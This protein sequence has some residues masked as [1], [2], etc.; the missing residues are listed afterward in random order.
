M[1]SAEKTVPDFYRRGKNTVLSEVAACNNFKISKKMV[2][3]NVLFNKYYMI[4]FIVYIE[5]AGA[6]E[7]ITK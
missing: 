4:L 5:I 1:R 3:Y 2:I 7:T 6:A